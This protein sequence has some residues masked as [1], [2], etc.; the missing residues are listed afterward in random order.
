MSFQKNKKRIR[1][2]PTLDNEQSSNV[3][4]FS[5]ENLTLSFGG[6]TVYF[7]RLLYKG[8]PA[9]STGPSS[10][11]PRFPS[12]IELKSAGR[13]GFVRKIYD[14]LSLLPKTTRSGV[15]TFQ[16]IVKYLRYLD[17]SDRQ[18]DFSEDNVLQYLSYVMNKY[19]QG[20][21]KTST[22]GVARAMFVYVLKQL[23]D[24]ALIRKL[25]SAKGYRQTT[26]PN[27]VRLFRLLDHQNH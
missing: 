15:T 10:T 2:T 6:D 4:E 21:I 5:P 17:S 25:P 14:I 13:E 26:T 27:A 24:T 16:E 1:Q 22:Y 20:E 7:I 3:T 9:L 19:L 8:C 11:P 23:N 18:S 12:S